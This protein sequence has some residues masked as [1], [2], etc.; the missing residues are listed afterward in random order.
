M[1]S[2]SSY[3]LGNIGNQLH[4]IFAYS[5]ALRPIC[6]NKT[7]FHRGRERGLYPIS[8]RGNFCISKMS[9][10]TSALTLQS[11]PALMAILEPFKF[12]SLGERQGNSQCTGTGRTKRDR[13]GSRKFI[14]ENKT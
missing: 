2:G 12:H 6:C 14:A 3:Y 9:L 8:C 1:C 5:F 11:R 13:T 4:Q 7:W 10:F